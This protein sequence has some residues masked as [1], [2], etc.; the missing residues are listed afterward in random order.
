MNM[1]HQ[2][3]KS[4]I[5]GWNLMSPKN[6]NNLETLISCSDMDVMRIKNVD[7]QAQLNQNKNKKLKRIAYLYD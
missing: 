7:K 1:H 5:T 3:L 2:L 6:L 4:I